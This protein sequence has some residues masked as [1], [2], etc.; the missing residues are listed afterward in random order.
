MKPPTT[1][2]E[3]GIGIDQSGWNRHIA[4]QI[5]NHLAPKTR[6]ADRERRRQ[7]QV[8]VV[9]LLR[10]PVVLQ[11]VWTV[12]RQAGAD[13]IAAEPAANPVIDARVG[14]QRAMRGVMHQVRGTK[15]APGRKQANWMVKTSTAA[16]A[17]TATR[18]PVRML[19]SSAS[20]DAI[21]SMR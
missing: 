17:R 9:S 19:N 8:R 4:E 16:R 14:K 18:S 10:I 3:S 2:R 11:M 12:T 1:P 20:H 5:A 7:T 21:A 6:T 15:I 13:R